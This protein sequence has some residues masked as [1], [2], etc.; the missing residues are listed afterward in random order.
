MISATRKSSLDAIRTIDKISRH[1]A[2]IIRAWC[3][4]IL[5]NS[6]QIYSWSKRNKGKQL[7]RAGFCIEEQNMTDK[8]LIVCYR[9]TVLLISSIQEQIKW[10]DKFCLP[11]QTLYEK[12]KALCRDLLLSDDAISDINDMRIRNV[13]RCR[14]VLGMT[15]EETAES[16]NVCTLTISKLEATAWKTI[17]ANEH[18][19]E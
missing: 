11:V 19:Q 1:H 12:R 2:G 3:L 9:D 5:M 17:Q 4:L 7:Q 13:I 8:E 15:I 6:F 16:M 14:Y 18:R 10:N